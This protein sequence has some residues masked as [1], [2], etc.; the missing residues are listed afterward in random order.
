M[1]SR[2]RTADGVLV[3][4]AMTFFL[5][6]SIEESGCFGIKGFKEGSSSALFIVLYGHRSERE[7]KKIRRDRQE[8]NFN[9]QVWVLFF[10]SFRFGKLRFPGCYK[11]SAQ[12]LPA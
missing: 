12:V 7:N 5:R 10:I 9:L 3:S 11:S 8:K 2:A 1:A 6:F 4:T